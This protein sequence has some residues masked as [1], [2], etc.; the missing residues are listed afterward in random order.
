[1]AETAWEKNTLL[2]EHL[3]IRFKTVSVDLM[4]GRQV[5]FDQ[6]DLLTA[7]RATTAFPGIFSPLMHDGMMLVDGGVLNNL[8][9]EELGQ[10][11]V[12]WSLPSMLRGNTRKIR[13]AIW[14]KLCTALTA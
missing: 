9:V 14:S 2:I 4:Q 3:P 6:G 5:V 8:P 10:E 11:K 7:L 12:N 1:M 13:R